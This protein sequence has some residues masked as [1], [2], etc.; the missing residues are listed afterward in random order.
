MSALERHYTTAEVAKLWQV[1]QDTVRNI[2]RD[3]PGVV[4]IAR[5]ETR[6]KRTY[7]SFRIPQSVLETVHAKLRKGA[8]VGVSPW[9]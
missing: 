3:V 5:P 7:T 8:P 2:F 9:S 6:S 1:S 4:K